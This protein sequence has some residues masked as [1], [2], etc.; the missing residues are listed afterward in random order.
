MGVF[1]IPK[2]IE[3]SKLDGDEYN[4]RM[5]SL[6]RTLFVEGLGFVWFCNTV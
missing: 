4:D 1:F 5:Y 6:D 2:L 3:L